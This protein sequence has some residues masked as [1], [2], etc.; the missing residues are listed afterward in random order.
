MTRRT[1]VLLVV[2]AILAWAGIVMTQL[3]VAITSSGEEEHGAV[4]HAGRT[5]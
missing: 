1:T 2:V 4:A 5:R 3:Q